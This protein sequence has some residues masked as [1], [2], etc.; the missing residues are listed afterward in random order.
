MAKY[1]DVDLLRKEIEFAKSVYSNPERVVHGVADAY[2]QDGRAAMCDDILKKIDSLQQEP[3]EVDLEKF[4]EKMDAWKARYNYPDNIPIKGTMA[5]TARMFYMYPN[6]AREWYD[7]L[8]K[9]T[10]D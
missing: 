8:R 3:Q 7:S 1:I 4:T 9:V 10:L 2:R 6:V 5:F